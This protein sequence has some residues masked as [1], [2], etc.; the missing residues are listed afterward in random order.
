MHAKAKAQ[1]K[2]C[3]EK[4]KRGDPAFKSLTT[5]MKA[6]LRATVGEVYW[7]K[8]HDYL[9]HFLKQKQN[10]GSRA[11]A[12][13]RAQQLQQQQQ[14]GGHPSQVGGSSQQQPPP[15]VRTSAPGQPRPGMAGV[16]SQAQQQI[17]TQ[18][19][20]AAAKKMPLGSS[21]S[22][23]SGGIPSTVQTTGSTTVPPAAVPLTAEQVK[24]QKDAEEAEKRRQRN[25]Q[26][27]K[28]R[29]IK[30]KQKEEQAA[31]EA[32]K[33]ATHTSQLVSAAAASKL[34]TANLP[35]SVP[36]P[37]M[38]SAIPTTSASGA[39]TSQSSVLSSAS[40]KSKDS[41]KS[42]TDAAKKKKKKVTTTTSSSGK[43]STSS[44]LLKR[45]NSLTQS[46]KLMDNIDHAV[47]I[48]VKSLPNLLSK[49]YKT[50]VNLDEEQ[51]I[52]LYGDEKRQAKVKDIA[53]AAAA[54]LDNNVESTSK[55]ASMPPGVPP[56]P[57][58]IPAMLE[59]W[60]TKN[61]VAVRTAWA[62]IRLPE[63]EAIRVEMEQK[64]ET[65]SAAN[66]EPK[67]TAMRDH[68]SSSGLT[69]PT[70]SSTQTQEGLAAEL[71][72][73]DDTTNH[74]WC[75]ESRAEQDPTLAMLSEATEQFLKS[76]IEKAIGKA[77]LRQNLDGV[78]LWHTLHAQSVN[79]AS[80]TNGNSGTGKK[81]P[82]ALLRLGC[83]VR[84]QIALA[85]GNAAKTY[86]RMEDAITRQNDTYHSD[87]SAQDPDKMLMEA[88][89]MADLSRKPPLKSASQVADLD[90][91]RKFAV[92]GGC[93]SMEPP[94][95]RVP[96]KAKVTLQD[97]EL[98]DLGN[99]TSM[100][101]ARRKRFRVGLR[102]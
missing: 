19:Q 30:K 72:I 26:A 97:I 10:S 56:L 48:D 6:R 95:G 24:K 69:A 50:D 102:Y 36:A 49:E 98:G 38:G 59:G 1:I 79:N 81:P 71:K 13:Q 58:S 12:Q 21:N 8:A 3:Y 22:A 44:A 68:L 14:R 92:F 76:A 11:S 62:K 94:L 39:L 37:A 46:N 63:S 25:E 96:K 51:R 54:A 83:D 80:T 82:A 86:Q 93:D 64:Q 42:K 40:S 20:A 87:P 74:V 47:L 70:S 23:R 60:G 84:R 2:E 61:V 29:A 31:A 66:G 99:R 33:K 55:E 15:I 78:R 53:K 17:L 5:S 28:R 101:R 16:Q 85:E 91:K 7:R 89:S 4:N 88:T 57:S 32:K 18:Q 41:S 27:K 90:A 52:L 67:L 9:E 35:S 34:A 73:E 75:N 100:I 45:K 77:R 43:A 65:A